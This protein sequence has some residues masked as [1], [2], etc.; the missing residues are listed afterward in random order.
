MPSSFYNI[1]AALC[2][3]SI[4]THLFQPCVSSPSFRAYIDIVLRWFH[5]CSRLLIGLFLESRARARDWFRSLVC[6]RRRHRRG[7]YN[8]DAQCLDGIATISPSSR[9]WCATRHGS[10]FVEFDREEEEDMSRHAHLVHSRQCVD[11]MA[12]CIQT[13][14][15]QS[16]EFIA[17]SKSFN[18][19]RKFH[20]CN[21]CYKSHIILVRHEFV[22]LVHWCW[23][24]RWMKAEEKRARVQ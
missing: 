16:L 8:L 24:T 19:T 6:N 3:H 1:D 7:W 15:A 14:N 2:A 5:R 21:V 20:A 11:T 17:C 22:I 18:R 4:F 12:I 9:A 13:H 10:A 23:R